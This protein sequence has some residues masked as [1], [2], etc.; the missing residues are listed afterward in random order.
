MIRDSN[1]ILNSNQFI[2]NNSR[3]RDKEKVVNKNKKN[4]YLEWII[5]VI[6]AIVVALLINRFIFFNVYVP[7]PSMVPTININDR[8]IVT[9]VYNKENLRVGDII[10]FYSDEFNERLVKRLI[11]L[12]GDKIDIKDGVVFRNGEKLNEDYV[13]NKDTFNGTYE[14]PEGKYF[15]LGDN[16]PG[17][18][19]SRFWKNPYVDAADIEGKVQFRYYPLKDLGTVK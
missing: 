4:F 1:K 9:K 18:D 14:V 6:S 13:K 2:I 19:D 16:R 10:V 3:R 5:P 8:F 12:P 7:T 15:F 11:G 17:S